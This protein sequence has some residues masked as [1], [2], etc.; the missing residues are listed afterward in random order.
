VI[1]DAPKLKRSP[2]IAPEIYVSGTVPEATADLFSLGVILFEMLVGSPPFGCSTDL[3]RT[4]GTLSDVRARRLREVDGIAPK[5]VE[6]VCGLIQQ[7]PTDRIANAAKVLTSL[8]VATEEVT[9]PSTKEA[10]PRL[11]DGSQS[12]LYNISSFL[13]TGAEAQIYQAAGVRGKKVAL[14]LFNRDVP[15]PRIVDEQ[16]FAATAHHSS[17]VRSI[18]TASGRTAATSLLSTG[19]RNAAFE[20]SSTR[21]TALIAKLFLAE[22]NSFWKHSIRFTRI[23]MTASIILSSTMTSSRRTF[24]LPNRGA[25]F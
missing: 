2:Y 15:L 4:G 9:T 6:I 11:E 20:T 8:D 21:E 1:P 12:G 16:E 25:R 14:K 23:P 7:A 10:N 13:K 19:F 17:L 24:L 3:E 22:W 18:A 5:V